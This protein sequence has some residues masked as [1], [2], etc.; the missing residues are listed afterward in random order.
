[1]AKNGIQLIGG[2]IEMKIII[3][4]GLLFMSICAAA[5]VAV[6]GYFLGGACSDHGFNCYH[7]EI[8]MFVFETISTIILFTYL[9]YDLLMR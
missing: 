4:F 3:I 8:G 1:M 5:G 6:V 2:V 7:A 9:F